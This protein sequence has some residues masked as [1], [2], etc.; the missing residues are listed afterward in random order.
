MEGQYLMKQNNN[1]SC[2]FILHDGKLA[3]EIN[4]VVKKNILPG[5]GFG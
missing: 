1:A 2:F 5:E 4:G 3:L